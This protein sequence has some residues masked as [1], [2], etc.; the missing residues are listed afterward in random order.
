MA[1]VVFAACAVLLASTFSR[2]ADPKPLWELQASTERSTAPG[3]LAYSPDERK[4]QLTVNQTG[5]AQLQ[6]WLNSV[7]DGGT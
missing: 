5:L 3:W 2:A 4:L 6:D 1:R 7:T